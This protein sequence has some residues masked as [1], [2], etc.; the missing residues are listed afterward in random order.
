VGPQR[1]R[2]RDKKGRRVRVRPLAGLGP[3]GMRG[4]ENGPRAAGRDLVGPRE[5]ALGL[6]WAKSRQGR[7]ILFFF[8]FQFFQSIFQKDFESS[9][10]FD[11]NHSIQK[12]KCSSMNAQS[13]FYPYI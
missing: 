8:L 7:K 3:S 2:Q 6:S 5:T 4:K 9:F 1:Q 10:E 11:S 13:C 12:F